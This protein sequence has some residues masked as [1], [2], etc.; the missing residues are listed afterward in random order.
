M[1]MMKIF[2][3]SPYQGNIEEN[4][5][6]AAY[7]AKIVAK[8]GNVPVAP[9]IY[10]PNFLDEKNSNERMTGI[11]MGLELMDTC[12]MVYVFGF[13]I[14]EHAKEMKKPVR[15]YDRNFEQIC[16]KTLPIDDRASD[17]YRSLLKGQKLMR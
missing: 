16:V 12:D 8:S 15:L 3:C 7:Y 5:K 4:K 10:F 2:I 17:E 13:E 14:T 11:E 1:I 9:H 6:K